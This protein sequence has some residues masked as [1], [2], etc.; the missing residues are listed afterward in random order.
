[1]TDVDLNLKGLDKIL[2]SLKVKNIP[3]IKVGILG[4]NANRGG[5]GP[6]NATIGA[7]HEFGT[8]TIP[9]RS[10]LRVPIAE[11]MQKKMQG[12]GAFNKQ[13]MDETIRSGTLLPMMKK[14][15]VLA[16]GIVLEAFD[17]GGYGKWAPWVDPS[18]KNN[19]GQLLVDTQQ[20][21]NS[22]TAEVVE[23]G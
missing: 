8:S 15:A 5:N 12:S 1:M 2:K 14:I 11:N 7:Y 22:V 18:Y 10:F 20:L 21:R 9:M 13:S 4:S 17:T 23:Q 19:T 6:N 16:E 3:K